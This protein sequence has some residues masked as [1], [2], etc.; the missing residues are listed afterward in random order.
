M[1]KPTRIT[2]RCGRRILG[3]QREPRYTLL[4]YITAEE[5]RNS[6]GHLACSV[7]AVLEAQLLPFLNQANRLLAEMVWAPSPLRPWEID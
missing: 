1:P 7:G 4:D 6:Q 3:V 5:V 2:W